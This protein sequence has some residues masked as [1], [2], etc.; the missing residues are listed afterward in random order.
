MSKKIQSKHQHVAP[1]SEFTVGLVSSPQMQMSWLGQQKMEEVSRKDRANM[2][3]IKS[4]S[5][6]GVRQTV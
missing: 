2:N 3:Y 6:Q 5:N 1:S 4:R